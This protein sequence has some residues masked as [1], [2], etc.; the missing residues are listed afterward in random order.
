MAT[1]KTSKTSDIV[2]L[3]QSTNKILL[4]ASTKVEEGLASVAQLLSGNPTPGVVSS[5][6]NLVDKHWLKI[7]EANK[8]VARELLL[9]MTDQYDGAFEAPFHGKTYSVEK[10]VSWK[11][12][13]SEKAIRDLLASKKLDPKLALDETI[14]YSVNADKVVS[15]V[16]EGVLTQAEVDGLLEV[17]Q[18]A[19]KVEVR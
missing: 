14:T 8:T 11:R 15:L 3:P 5:V 9:E 17:H 12:L 4:A 10:R 18:T 1:K 7:L 13:P 16:K 2:V 19:L 6:Y